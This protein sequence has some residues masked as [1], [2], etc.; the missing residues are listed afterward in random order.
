MNHQ[1][2]TQGNVFNANRDTN[3]NGIK[4]KDFLNIIN[5]I[6]EETSRN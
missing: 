1:E 5:E 2:T 4:M 3:G 6:P